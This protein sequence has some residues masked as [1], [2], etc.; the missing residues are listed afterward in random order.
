MMKLAS[1]NLRVMPL[2]ANID[3]GALGMAALLTLIVFIGDAIDGLVARAR[4]EANALGAVIDIA[5]DRIVENVCWL[6]CSGC[7]A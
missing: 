7:R 2:I 6:Y 1:G 4:G 3:T 5:G